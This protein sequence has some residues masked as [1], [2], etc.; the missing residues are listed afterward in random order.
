ML[1]Q[2]HPWITF[3]PEEKLFVNDLEKNVGM[4]EIPYKI[5][6][7]DILLLAALYAYLLIFLLVK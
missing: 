4:E 6:C 5:F 3:L 7:P 1:G 2:L